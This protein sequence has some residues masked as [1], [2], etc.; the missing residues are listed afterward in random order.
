MDKLIIKNRK[1]YHDYHILDKFEAGLGLKGHEVKA[2][3]EGKVNIREAFCAFESNE[4]FLVQAHISPYSHRG[5]VQHDPLRKK[6]LL[7]HKSELNRLRKKRDEQSAT[8]VP[9]AMYWKG[10]NIKL[11]IGLAKGKRNVDKRQDIAAKDAKR[12]MDRRMKNRD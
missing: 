1:A 6:K 8:I 2:I 7:L 4:L 5:Y 9:L 3:R 10:N 11:E 12:Q